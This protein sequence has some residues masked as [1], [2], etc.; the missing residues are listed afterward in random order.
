MIALIVGIT[1]VAQSDWIGGN[2]TSCSVGDITCLNSCPVEDNNFGNTFCAKDTSLVYYSPGKL[3][4]YGTFQYLQEH[5]IKGPG[6]AGGWDNDPDIFD[7]NQDGHLDLVVTDESFLDPN[8]SVWVFLNDGNGNFTQINVDWELESVDEIHENDADNDGDI[9]LFTVGHSD[10]DEDVV[11][12][13]NTGAGWAKCVICQNANGACDAST[14]GSGEVEGIYTGDLDGDGDVDIAVSHLNDGAL[15]VFERVPEGTPGATGCTIPGA[16]SHYY[17]KHLIDD[18]STGLGWNVVVEDGDGDGDKDIFMTYD[19]EVSFYRNS[20]G[21]TFNRETIHSTP[22]N[23]YY[24]L[25]VRDIDGDG[26]VDVVVSDRNLHYVRIFEND[27]TGHFSLM[28][29]FS[30]PHPMGVVIND[31]EEDGDQDIFVASY[32]NGATPNDSTIYVIVNDGGTFT[33]HNQNTSIARRSYFGVGSG[34]LDGDGDADLLVRAGVPGSNPSNREGL[35]WYDAVLYY[36]DSATVVS[37]IVDINGPGD[38]HNW[39]WDSLIIRGKNLELLNFYFR[40]AYTLADLADSGWT[41]PVDVGSCTTYGTPVDSIKCVIS[42]GSFTRYVEFLQYKIVLYSADRD[43]DGNNETSAIIYDVAFTFDELTP[44]SSDEQQTP[45]IRN[46]TGITIFDVRG[47]MVGRYPPMDTKSI[48][49]MLK[50]GIYIIHMETKE[51]R[52]FTRK[53][54]VGR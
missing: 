20:G 6:Q 9:D 40:T 5:V 30:I 47:R 38:T 49:R 22:G 17:V 45:V 25:A 34:D 53:L 42:S 21:L 31:V 2:N 48:S 13:V 27:G 24:G 11:L 16:G 3:R 26:D 8:D 15:Y 46:I 41:T 44:V 29:S 39:K 50:P 43:L 32:R 18:P 51:G 33:P 54:V 10:T 4:I 52:K 14:P 28:G 7:V 36:H 37:N 19:W 12:F 23:R 1:T 35:Y